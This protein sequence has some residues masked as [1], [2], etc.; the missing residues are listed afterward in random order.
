VEALRDAV[1]DLPQIEDATTI[2]RL[3]TQVRSHH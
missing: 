1:L 2:A 3:L